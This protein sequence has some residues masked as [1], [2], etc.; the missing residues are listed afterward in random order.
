[1]VIFIL[2]FFRS[3][4][5]VT[6]IQK[7][8]I[9]SV[10]SVRVPD[11]RARF[12]RE[13]SRSQTLTLSLSVLQYTLTR[14]SLPV[15]L[16]GV[17]SFSLTCQMSSML[18]STHLSYTSLFFRF[19]SSFRHFPGQFLLKT[20]FFSLRIQVLSLRDFTC[21]IHLFLSHSLE[22]HAHA[23]SPDLSSSPLVLA[24]LGAVTYASAISFSGGIAP[25]LA[26]PIITTRSPEGT[27][28]TTPRNHPVPTL[29]VPLTPAPPELVCSAIALRRHATLVRS[30]TCVTKS[31]NKEKTSCSK[32]SNKERYE[33]LKI[34]QEREI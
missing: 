9:A 31:S 30:P 12:S 27:C 18:T 13:E 17:S 11:H 28:F 10:F 33:L 6:H 3:S 5:H 16:V 4:A 29:L 32:S 22:S 8:K 23:S 24:N 7:K 14:S 20:F 34:Q 1:M 15:F 2:I 26:T 21:P 25:P 19:S